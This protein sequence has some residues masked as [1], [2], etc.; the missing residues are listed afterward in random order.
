[1]KVSD[2]GHDPA[3]LPPG[4]ESQYS[5]YGTLSGTP[6]KVWTR[7]WREKSLYCPYR[8]S[9]TGCPVPSL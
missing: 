4:K 8:E 2:Q 6:K 1:M 3:A 9:N 5:S 7:W